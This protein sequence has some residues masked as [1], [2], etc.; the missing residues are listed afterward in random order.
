MNK[1]IGYSLLAIFILALFWAGC[2]EQITQ[3]DNRPAMPYQSLLSANDGCTNKV[4][5]LWAAAGQNDLSKGEDVGDVI[6]HRH[7]ILPTASRPRPLW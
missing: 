1:K 4:A 2:Q 5:D 6:A 3:P 7:I